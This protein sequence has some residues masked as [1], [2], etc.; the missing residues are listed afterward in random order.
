MFR[1]IAALVLLTAFVAQTFT[2]P[3]VLLDYYANTAAYAK[4]CINKARPKLHCNGKCQVMKKMREEEKQQ[5]ENAQ[6]FGRL[7]TEVLSTRSFYP[8]LI[9]PEP[10]VIAAVK[11]AAPSKGRIIRRSFGF[12]HP[13]QAA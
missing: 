13:P 9:V 3:F 2:A 12:F 11:N 10:V 4:N 6:R 8:S 1:R 5:Q 7:K